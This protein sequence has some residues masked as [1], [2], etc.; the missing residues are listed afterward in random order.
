MKYGIIDLKTNSDPR[1]ALTSVEEL[2]D[3]P[4]DIKRIFYIFESSAFSGNHYIIFY[5]S[6][7]V[8]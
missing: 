2:F 4:I 6:S 8:K 1:G 5:R 7:Q 3:I